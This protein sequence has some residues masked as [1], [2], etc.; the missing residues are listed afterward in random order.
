MENKFLTYKQFYALVL[1]TVVTTNFII[2]PFISG[3]ILSVT[4]GLM[5]TLIYILFYGKIKINNIFIKYFFSIKFMLTSGILIGIF[6]EISKYFF[7]SNINIY[8]ILSVVFAATVYCSHNDKSIGSV[9]RMLYIFILIPVLSVILFSINDIKITNLFNGFNISDIFTLSIVSM[10]Y[11]SVLFLGNFTDRNLTYKNIFFP[12]FISI[13]ILFLAN[14]CIIGRFGTSVYNYKYPS[15][16]LMYSSDLPGYIVQRQEGI[17]ISLFLI[18]LL[19]VISLFML[20]S[21]KIKT[22]NNKKYINYVLI[23]ITAAFSVVYKNI[24]ELYIIV[25]FFGGICIL[26]LSLLIRGEKVEK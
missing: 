20:L 2:I 19:V 15:F 10:I 26:I 24:M 25:S 6:S 5:L 7:L 13:C 11:E 4:A 17:L 18:G 23:Y 12:V 22:I 14:I 3:S 16:E 8:I 21:L 1:I 9:G